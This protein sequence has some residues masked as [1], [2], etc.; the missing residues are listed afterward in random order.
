MLLLILIMEKAFDFIGKALSDL[1]FGKKDVNERFQG[2]PKLEPGPVYSTYSSF[3]ELDAHNR[4]G[5]III[6]F[7]YIKWNQQCKLIRPIWDALK[8]DMAPGRIGGGLWPVS[9]PYADWSGIVFVENDEEEAPT[10]GIDSVPT[11]VRFEAGKLHVYR[12][13]FTYKR[14]REWVLNTAPPHGTVY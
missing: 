8:A 11:L 2:Y 5:K 14:I 12:G 3:S 9:S 10:P 1:F 6:G 7:H 13:P 4:R